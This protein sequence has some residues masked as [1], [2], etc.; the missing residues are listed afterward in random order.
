MEITELLNR[1]LTPDQLEELKKRAD[2]LCKGVP[3]VN[4]DG[5]VS[6]CDYCD[7]TG[8]VEVS[9]RFYAVTPQTDQLQ[10][11]TI[12]EIGEVAVLEIEVGALTTSS[13]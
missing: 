12:P 10:R 2:C 5:D 6:V 11:V 7:G 8:V 13:T 3:P 1:L 4:D 9:R